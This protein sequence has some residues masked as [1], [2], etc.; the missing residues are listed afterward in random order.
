MKMQFADKEG[1]FLN[2]ENEI[3]CFDASA[4]EK[5]NNC[6]LVRKD[7]LLDYLLTHH[8]KIIW[9]VLGEKNIIGLHNWHKLPNLPAWLVVSGTYTLDET[10][11]V[12]GS[13]RASRR[14]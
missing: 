5:S 9:Y 10:G 2:E 14:R 8:K 12:V 7:A 4:V 6:F 3:I 1:A 13:L 11:K